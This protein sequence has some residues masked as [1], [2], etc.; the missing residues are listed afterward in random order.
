MRSKIFFS[1]ITST[2]NSEKFIQKNLES[3]KSQNFDNFEHII[4]DGYSSDNTLNIIRSFERRFPAYGRKVRIYKHIPKGVAD[5]FNKGVIHAKGEYLIHLN[6]D[7]FFNDPKVLSRSSRFIEKNNF[8]DWIYGRVLVIDHRGRKIGIFPYFKI[9]QE[10][11]YELLKV[12]NYIQHQ[13]VFIR[14]DVF[15]KLGLFDEKIISTDYE[16][17][18]RIG[19]RTRWLFHNQIVAKFRIHP[20]S[21][22]WGKM[23]KRLI[24]ETT[25]KLNKKYAN[26]YQYLLFKFINYSYPAEIYRKIRYRT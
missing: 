14:K 2:L 3:V 12:S 19:K 18:L 13:S 24:R 6:S 11:N 10:S 9:F 15:K 17:W 1:V 20:G 16:Y 8:P 25:L 26:W 21:L 5:S 4:I 23:E 22:T 7:D